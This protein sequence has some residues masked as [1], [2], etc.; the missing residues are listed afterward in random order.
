LILAAGEG[1]GPATAS[2]AAHLSRVAVTLDQNFRCHAHEGAHPVKTTVG[3]CPPTDF[4]DDDTA[5]AVEQERF[6]CDGMR[7]LVII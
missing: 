7:S 5:A 3:D 4:A 1:H 2:P 6:N